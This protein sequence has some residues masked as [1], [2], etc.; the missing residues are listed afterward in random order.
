MTNFRSPRPIF[1]HDDQFFFIVTNFYHGDQLF[2]T[3]TKN[4]RPHE[5]G[6]VFPNQD[7]GESTVGLFYGLLILRSTSW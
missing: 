4:T 1:W 7:H 3:M 5:K 2:V 6:Q